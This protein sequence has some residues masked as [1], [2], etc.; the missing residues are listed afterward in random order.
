MGIDG[1]QYLEIY[2]PSE[3]MDALE[4]C[5]LVLQS[6]NEKLAYIGTRFFGKECKL[7]RIAF[8]RIRVSYE[9]R[10]EPIY[11]YLTE[12]L[13]QHPKC[14][15]KNEYNTE[16]GDCAIWVAR[17]MNGT[18]HIKHFEWHELFIEEAMG[19]EDF[20]IQ[21]SEPCSHQNIVSED[22][23]ICSP[24]VSVKKVIKKLK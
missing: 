10:N 24:V 12:L 6:E 3:S 17:M 18:P 5:G 4:A 1:R 2:G 7:N 13:L 9:F 22:D 8:N 23:E 21:T 16:D 19:S 14:W 20:S 15:I 11:N